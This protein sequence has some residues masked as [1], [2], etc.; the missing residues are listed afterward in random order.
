M[1]AGK[2]RKP[3]EIVE[4]KLTPLSEVEAALGIKWTEVL[5]GDPKSNKELLPHCESSETTD[6]YPVFSREQ[7][8]KHLKEFEENCVIRWLNDDIGWILTL[9]KGG[10]LSKGVVAYTGI[11]MDSKS[12]HSD[13][14]EYGAQLYIDKTGMGIVDA[15]KSGNLTRLGACLLSDKDADDIFEIDAKIQNKFDSADLELNGAI[16]DGKL[17]PGLFIYKDLVATDKE[18]M[19]GYNY[20]FHYI[21]TMSEKN[22]IFKLFD[23]DTHQPINNSLYPERMLKIKGEFASQDGMAGSKYEFS[24]RRVDVLAGNHSSKAMVYKG[25][26][27]NARPYV[28]AFTFADMYRALYRAENQKELHLTMMHEMGLMRDEVYHFL[29]DK[30]MSEPKPKVDTISIQ[31]TGLVPLSEFELARVEAEKG[32]KS[33][34]SAQEPKSISVSSQSMFSVEQKGSKEKGLKD[35]TADLS[36]VKKTKDTQDTT[37]IKLR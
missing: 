23:I 28:L 1:F 25:E 19:L 7:Y 30:M 35:S 37:S 22:K 10:K 4:P 8:L 3:G 26:G 14:E 36:A 31:P 11:A 13:F 6:K 16:I 24:V 27:E 2:P 15:S 34:T 32:T 17:T 5:L 21:A 29:M 9:R 20:G 12:G 18:I 33:K